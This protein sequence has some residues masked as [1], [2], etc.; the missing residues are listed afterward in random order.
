MTSTYATAMLAL[1]TTIGTFEV[2]KLVYQYLK[3]TYD[4]KSGKYIQCLRQRIF[5]G[6]VQD[7]FSC[8]KFLEVVQSGHSTLKEIPLKNK[9]KY[10]L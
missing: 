1:K 4:I 3:V 8:R 9:S 2:A 10:S 5:A 6:L 7:T